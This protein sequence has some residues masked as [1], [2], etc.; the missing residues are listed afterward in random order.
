V[1]EALLEFPSLRHVKVEDGPGAHLG[2]SFRVK[3]WLTLVFLKDGKEVAR[4]VCPR[5]AEEIR[6]E[7]AKAHD[8]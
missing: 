4:I 7:L 6:A 3:L 2:R 1:E 5:N 8:D